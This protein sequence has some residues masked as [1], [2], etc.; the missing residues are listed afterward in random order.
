MKS[1]IAHYSE[2]VLPEQRGNPLI[3][4]LPVLLSDHDVLLALSHFPEL[5]E[6][7]RWDAPA[8][9]REQYVDR[10]KQF[11]C[12][13]ENYIECYKYISRALRDGYSS[14]NPL[15]S[16]T[17]QYLHYYTNERPDIEPV[18]GYFQSCADTVTIVGVSGSGKTTMLEQVLGYFPQVIEHV[19]YKGAFPG[20]N[21]QVVWLKVNCPY[22]ASVRDLCEAILGALDKVLDSGVTIPANRNGSLARQIEQKIKSSF[23]GVLVIDEMQRLKFSRTGGENTLIDFLHEIVDSLGVPLVFCGN[24]PFDE[25]LTR[26]LRIARRAESGGYMKISSPEYNSSD[27]QTFINYLWP[28]QW[29]NVESPLTSELNEKLFILSKGNIGLAQ[30]I[31]KR[32]QMNV[33]GS[34]NETINCAVLTSSTPPLS[35]NS[36][37]FINELIPGTQGRKKL[38]ISDTPKVGEHQ[39]PFE[40]KMSVSGGRTVEKTPVIP[41]DFNRPQHAEF[42]KV[43]AGVMNNLDHHLV[44]IEHLGV[45]RALAQESSTYSQLKRYGLLCTDPLN[46]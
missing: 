38:L 43:I 21:K 2:A 26:K 46:E 8:V 39:Y 17:V 44:Q 3:E 22:N 29:T 10:I 31:Y 7:I 11:R 33:I 37:E 40:Q 24:H 13:Q 36:E 4:A 1:V 16:S 15:K 23:L 25:T 12:P 19:N 18:D 5:D 9:V 34:G 20:F 6:H 14:R 30:A 27:W 35:S 45:I 42:S 41:G 28:L 32:A